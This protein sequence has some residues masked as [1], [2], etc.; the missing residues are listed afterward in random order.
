MLITS[1]QNP[2]VKKA[3]SLRE[4]KAR[5][6][7]GLTIIDGVRELK[8]ALD[9][10]VAFD[11][12]F[13]CPKLFANHGQEE[14]LAHIMKAKVETIEVNEMVFSKMA[15]GERQEGLLGLAVIPQRKLEALRL[16]KKPLLVIVESVE[17]P[18]NLGAIARTCDAVGADALIVC[19]AKTDIYNPN[20][21]RASTGIV[22][23]LPVVSA[24][25]EEV[26]AFLK[27]KKI[28]ACATIVDAKQLYTQ[29][30]LSGALAMILGTED[31]GL[32]DFWAKA[33]DIKIKIPMHGAADSLNV[34]TSAAIV[35]YE[36]LRQRK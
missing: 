13:F 21:I 29:A 17:K 18:G 2:L 1:V 4:P 19:D 6:E 3:I 11:Q 27:A 16:S 7:L 36:A 9:S 20:V 14:L 35:L 25:K 34:S 31:K 33:A 28:K 22:F 8:R 10:G 15:F 32:S 24:T 30:D 12:V 26:A 23:S 5:K